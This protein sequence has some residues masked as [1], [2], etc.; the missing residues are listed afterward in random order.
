M[1][2]DLPREPVGMVISDLQNLVL[3]VREDLV[4]HLALE[5][6][7]IMESLYPVSVKIRLPPIVSGRGY[8]PTNQRLFHGKGRRFHGTKDLPFLF[9]G[10]PTVPLS[11]MPRLFLSRCTSRT[12]SATAFLRASFSSLSR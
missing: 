11:H 3:L 8:V 12:H 4:P 10:H 6:R 1:K 9:R 2:A 7:A 5:R